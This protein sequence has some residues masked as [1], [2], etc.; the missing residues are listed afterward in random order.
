M[1]VAVAALA[2]LVALITWRGQA[3]HNKLSVRPLAAVLHN[4]LNRRI[5]VTLANHGTGP[6]L[7]DKLRVLSKGGIVGKSLYEQCDEWLRLDWFVGP[8]DGRSIPVEGKIDL[9]IYTDE[10]ESDREH[11]RALLA[12]LEIEVVYRDIYGELQPTYSRRLDWFSREGG[13]RKG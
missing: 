2:V 11:L 13:R 3:N 9:L 7:I 5:V 8:V 1:E 4:D 6:L 12:D 10:S